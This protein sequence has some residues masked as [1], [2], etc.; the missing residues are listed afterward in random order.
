M[1]YLERLKELKEQRDLTNA[2]IAEVSEIP[3]ATVTRI[4]NG[5]TPNPQ[6]ETIARI[7]MALGGSLDFIAGMKPMEDKPL[8][9]GVEQTLTNYAEMLRL[10]DERISDLKADREHDRKEKRRL[11]WFIAGF[12]SFVLFI[13]IFDMMNGHFGYFRY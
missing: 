4:F 2:E 9:H 10:K 13:L 8:G 5:Q 1:G 6:F 7:T 11:M 12:V 3:L